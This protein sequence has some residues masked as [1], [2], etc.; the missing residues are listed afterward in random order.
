MYHIVTEFTTNLDYGLNSMGH[1]VLLYFCTFV[2]KSE[3]KK[4]EKNKIQQMLGKEKKS[5]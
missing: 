2:K 4:S 1:S 5:L 3:K